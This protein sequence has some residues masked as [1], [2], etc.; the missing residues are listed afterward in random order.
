MVRSA[1]DVSTVATVAV[2][3]VMRRMRPS[4]AP[5]LNITYAR[6]DWSWEAVQPADATVTVLDE[7]PEICPVVRPSTPDAT[8]ITG[9]IGVIAGT[10]GVVGALI[11][12]LTNPTGS[13][14][15]VD[16]ANA[17]GRATDEAR[18]A[19]REKRRKFILR[20]S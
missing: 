6:L 20:S 4:R 12:V 14:V 13:V 5:D 10:P 3:A 8:T 1:F 17:A 2:L 7:T 15:A 9:E 18:D 11:V 16:C 19:T